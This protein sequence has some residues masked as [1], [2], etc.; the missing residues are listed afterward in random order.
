[1]EPLGRARTITAPSSVS[2]MNWSISFR[3]GSCAGRTT[4]GPALPLDDICSLVVGS[5]SPAVAAMTP[6]PGP[7]PTMASFWATARW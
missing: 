4:G 2:S 1:M 6:M 7:V 3:L 5:S